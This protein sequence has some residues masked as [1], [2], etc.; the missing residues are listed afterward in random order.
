MAIAFNTA[1]LV[2]QFTDWRFQLSNWGAQDAL[3]ARSHRQNYRRRCH[4]IMCCSTC[5]Y[6]SK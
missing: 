1:N 5:F 3:S 6:Q 2:A 4:E